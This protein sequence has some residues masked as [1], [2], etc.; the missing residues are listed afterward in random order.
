MDDEIKK[1]VKA[2]K[3]N[4]CVLVL[5]P[6]I[7]QLSHNILADK[8]PKDFDESLK[9]A[10]QYYIENKIDKELNKYRDDLLEFDDYAYLK[11]NLW[12]YN[13]TDKDRHLFNF[14]KWFFDNTNEWNEPFKEIS[15]IPFSLILSLLPDTNLADTFESQNQPFSVSKYS[16]LNKEVPEIKHKINQERTLIY[17][18]LGDIDARDASFTFDHWYEFFRNL[19]HE[20]PSLPD[21]IINTLKNA[22]IILFVGVRIEKWYIQLLIK[23]LYTISSEDVGSFAFAKLKNK[24]ET[25]LARK[26]LNIIFDEKEPIEMINKIFN[27]CQENKIIRPSLESTSRIKATVFISYNHSDEQIADRLKVDLERLGIIVIIDKDNPIGF[28]IPKFI[29]ESIQKADFTI[30]LISRNF[31]TSPWVAQESLRAFLSAEIAHK[32]VLPCEIDESLKDETFRE[33]AMGM[34]DEKIRKISNSIKERLDSDEGIEDLE[35]QRRRLRELKN[36]YDSIIAQFRNKNRGDLRGN[37]Y[38]TGFQKLVESIKVYIS[39]PQ[40]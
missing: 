7:C 19:L 25:L 22:D 35:P 38:D 14:A 30:Q 20:N 18:L 1:I 5:G 28:E 17:Q 29:N 6:E 4:K 39:K 9:I 10:Y 2:I 8:K 34:F 32:T 16:R 31:L 21:Q 36:N 12:V 13:H 24:E 27:A 23:H 3:D 33:N 40:A 37:N 11:E 15:Q 26:R